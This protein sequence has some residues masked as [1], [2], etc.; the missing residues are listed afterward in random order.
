MPGFISSTSEYKPTP[1]GLKYIDHMVGNVAL[2]EMNEVA[3][4]YKKVMGFANLITFD[5]KDISTQFTAL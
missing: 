5:D 1:T 2:G 3:T 4:F